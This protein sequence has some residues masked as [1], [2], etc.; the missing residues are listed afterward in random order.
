MHNITET[1]FYIMKIISSFVS[2]F[3]VL[4]I[5]VMCLALFASFNT[6]LHAEEVADK[7]STYSAATYHL[8]DV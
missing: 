4:P 5:T 1:D 3:F 7:K 2:Y 8:N 6:Q